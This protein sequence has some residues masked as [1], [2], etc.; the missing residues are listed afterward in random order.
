[1]RTIR[2]GMILS[3]A[4][5]LVLTGTAQAALMLDINGNQEDGAGPTMT[6]WSGFVA[7]SKKDNGPLTTTIPDPFGT[8]SDVAVTITNDDVSGSGARWLDNGA[9]TGTGDTMQDLL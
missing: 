2:I 5:L 4:F 8:G 9:F 6:G 1:M 7:P 3:A